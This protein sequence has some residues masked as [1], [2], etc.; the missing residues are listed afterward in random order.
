M[1]K[2]AVTVTKMT[3]T[4][5]IEKFEKKVRANPLT[6]ETVAKFLTELDC[7]EGI[8]GI[9]RCSEVREYLEAREE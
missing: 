4:D 9:E 2:F 3:A 5:T 8:W 6:A 1:S 7:K